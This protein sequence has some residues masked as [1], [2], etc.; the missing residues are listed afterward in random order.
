MILG[1]GRQLEL[2]LA[3]ANFKEDAES[4][5]EMVLFS[6]LHMLKKEELAA[7]NRQTVTK[8]KCD[9]STML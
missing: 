6:L 9:S 8:S 4:D 1:A 3:A 2:K 7:A 5:L